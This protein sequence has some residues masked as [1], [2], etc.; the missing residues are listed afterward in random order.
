[1]QSSRKSGCSYR[2]LVVNPQQPERLPT[3]LVDVADDVCLLQVP[4][5]Q[6]LWVPVLRALQLLIH[7]Y[8][9]NL[10]MYKFSAHC[11]HNKQQ[12]I[13]VEFEHLHSYTCTAYAHSKFL[14]SEANFHQYKTYFLSSI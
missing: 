3:S 14:F 7:G 6:S 13:H 10:D 12:T 4:L 11:W 5:R 9:L 8:G 2:D 1:M